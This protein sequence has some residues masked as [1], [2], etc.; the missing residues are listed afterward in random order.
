MLSGK[1]VIQVRTNLGRK[2][3]LWVALSSTPRKHIE[4]C[5][6]SA[7]NVCARFYQFI[8]STLYR[9]CLF[10]F[11]FQDR[12]NSLGQLSTVVTFWSAFSYF[13]CCSSRTDAVRVSSRCWITSLRILVLVTTTDILDWMFVHADHSGSNHCRKIQPRYGSYLLTYSMEQSPSVFQLVKK[14]PAFCG[15]RWFITAFTSV[16]QLSLSWANS[17][18]SIPSH[19]T[20]WRSIL[21]LSSHLRLGSQVVSFSQVYL[22]KPCIHLSSPHTFYI[23]RLSHSSRF[24][25]TKNI[26]WGVLIITLF[27]M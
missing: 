11:N 22:P 12:V 2:M 13:V 10:L 1:K 9:N 5:S 27:V 24:D 14:F 16:H 20:S 8:V 6:F 7:I 19:P 17:I 23:R 25:H 15:T 3:L 21:M 18:Q 26:G 4:G